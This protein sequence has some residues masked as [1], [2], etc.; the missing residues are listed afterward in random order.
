MIHD[1]E[2]SKAQNYGLCR[3]FLFKVLFSMWKSREYASYCIL[4]QRLTDLPA[5]FYGLL[6]TAAQA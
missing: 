5:L 6:K 2:V 4:Y 3:F 1:F